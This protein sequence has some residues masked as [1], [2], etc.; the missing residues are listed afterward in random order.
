M[1]SA[2]SAVGY[3]LGGVLLPSADPYFWTVPG[4]T[5]YMD[6]GLLSFDEKST[7]FSNYSTTGL[8]YFGTAAEGYLALI[9]SLGSKGVLIAFGGY[10]NKF[11]TA[12]NVTDDQL[13]EHPFFN[14]NLSSISVY[15]IGTKAW[16]H[17]QATGETPRF[18][19]SGC[20]VLVSAPDKSSHS[21]Y[22]FGGWGGTFERS[23]GDVYVLS[24]PSFRWIRVNSESNVRSRHKCSLIGNNTMMAVGGIT[25]L[26]DFPLPI[27]TPQGCDNTSTFAQG[28]GMFSLND[29]SW[30]TG[31][32][33][34]AGAAPYRIHPSISTVIG[35]TSS[36]GATL[37]S[38]SGG[39]SDKALGQILEASPAVS[40]QSSNSTD[41]PNPVG[42]T[43]AGSVKRRLGPAAIAGIVIAAVVVLAM[44]SALAIFILRRH[45]S[46]KPSRC[47]FTELSGQNYRRELGDSEETMV[48]VPQ[49]FRSE[50]DD[51]SEKVSELHP[52]KIT[53]KPLPL[54][55]KQV[56]LELHSD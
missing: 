44:L 27:W 36:G 8:N 24:I 19:Y 16:Y 49:M 39:F 9:E 51:G 50:L 55:P 30:S 47:N 21:I 25:P 43:A 54:P 5:P 6:Q 3:Y 46:G 29:H 17:Q 11:G 48:G 14:Q 23:D 45:K 15:D 40:N 20:S 52:I 12:M 42:M 22:V 32:D 18:R 4:A 41:P 26:F 34:E 10:S 37:K 1:Q 31:W 7:T 2:S 33:P 56:F 35:G 53:E 38:P 13:V 28:L